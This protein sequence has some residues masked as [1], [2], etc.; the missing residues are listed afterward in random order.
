MTVVFLYSNLKWFVEEHYDRVS[1][2][3][4]QKSINNLG[5]LYLSGIETIVLLI[6]LKSLDDFASM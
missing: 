1:L 2:P 4:T 5:L 3:Q 6:F